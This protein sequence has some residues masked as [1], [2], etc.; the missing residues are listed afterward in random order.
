[1]ENR[2]KLHR[3]VTVVPALLIG[4]LLT[5]GVLNMIGFWAQPA[6]GASG[7]SS[8]QAAVGGDSVY[9]ISD[10]A[11]TSPLSLTQ[12]TLTG[13]ASGLVNSDLIFT[14]TVLPLTVTG[15]VTY[16]W[17]MSG[18]S[19][20]THTAGLTDVTQLSWALTGTQRVT[21]T[22]VNGYPPVTAT[23]PVLIEPRRVYLPFIGTP[24][25]DL[26]I[27]GVEVIQTVQT[28]GNTVP[29]VTGRPT[30]IR[31]YALSNRLISG[32]PVTISVAGTRHG[33]P[34]PGSPLIVATN[35]IRETINP[36]DL[37]SSVNVPLPFD[38]LSGPVSL[39]ITVDQDDVIHE[40][41]EG[42]NT[43]S[44]GVIFTDVPPLEIMIVPIDYT[45]T[46]T[47]QYFPGPSDENISDWIFRTFPVHAV[48]VTIRAPL[49]YAGD[50]SV[51]SEW[52]NLLYAVTNLKSTDGSPSELVYYGYLPSSNSA[53]ESYPRAWGG[54]GWIGMRT[55][56]GV[57]YNNATSSGRLA[58]HE[59][60]HNFGRRHAP[61]GG[62]SGVDPAYPYA[63]ASIGHYGLDTSQMTIWSPD[64]TK[65]LMSYCSPK[66]LSDYT[67]IGLYDNQR[68]YGAP[69]EAPPEDLAFFF[70]ATIPVDGAIEIL[71]GYALTD[72]PITAPGQSDYT[73]ELIGPDGR[74]VA[75]HPVAVLESPYEENPFQAISAVLPHP[76]GAIVEVRLV[77]GGQVRAARTL[78]GASAT[79]Q[80]QPALIVETDGRMR[81]VWG[82]AEEPALV[83]FKPDDRSTWTTLRL[84][85]TGGSLSLDPSAFPSAE[86]ILEISLGD[87][88][89]PTL[90]Q[91]PVDS[92]E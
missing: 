19:P 51:S 39:E 35:T 76:G 44:L 37:A 69:A 8:D 66:W 54:I 10:A 16:R 63:N 43:S 86:G 11:L 1:M 84:D 67:Y 50:M 9:G 13:P 32:Y 40:F 61:C 78:H 22:A 3:A 42:N 33:A 70:R 89:Q 79:P 41:N 80:T 83:R 31:V 7:I 28:P 64:T 58:A 27:A 59:I 5:A 26:T 38:W 29:L 30:V 25:T 88:L 21:V 18:L 49:A 17:E 60:G 23:L 72:V 57:R 24:T 4:L 90:W 55:S 81:L 91:I 15:N 48:N 53:G 85:Q 65:D 6:Q 82:A 20:L 77:Q 2:T 56:L 75:S 87:T 34:L 46:P 68:A 92:G 73:V 47:G 45:H 36:G 52:N 62:P 74:V 14:A 71:P 12:V